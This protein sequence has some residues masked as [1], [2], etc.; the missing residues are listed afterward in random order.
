MVLTIR[1]AQTDDANRLFAFDP[2]AQVENE[3]RDYLQAEIATRNCWVAVRDDQFVG[4]AVLVYTFFGNGFVELLYVHPEHRRA[5]FGAA[6]MRHCESIC[7]TPK[8]FTST[9]LS[10]LPMQALLNKL[11]YTLTGMVHN[12]DE[13]DPEIFYFK[14]VQS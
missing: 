5:G 10:N 14:R 7:R 4:Y 8:V 3:R 12:L 2:I 9:N 11:S 13:D 1:L 6:L